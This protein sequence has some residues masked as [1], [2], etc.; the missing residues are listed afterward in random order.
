MQEKVIY[1][2]MTKRY[3]ITSIQAFNVLKNLALNHPF[4]VEP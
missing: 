3:E 2:L 1:N 4:E